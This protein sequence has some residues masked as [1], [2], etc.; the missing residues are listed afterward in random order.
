M[1]HLFLLGFATISAA[2]PAVADSVDDFRLKA[3]WAEVEKREAA[4]P[5]PGLPRIDQIIIVG[6]SNTF[7][8]TGWL[9]RKDWLNG[10]TEI[11]ER[12]FTTMISRPC[13][14]VIEE[15]FKADG[16]WLEQTARK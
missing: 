9:Q 10:K 15:C 8:V 14:Q 13:W 12:K 3:I 6:N 5:V 4:N 7:P 1:K 2:W 11:Y 16:M